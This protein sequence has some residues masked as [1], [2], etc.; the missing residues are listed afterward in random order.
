MNGS[1]FFVCNFL[2]VTDDYRV[3]FYVDASFECNTM[4]GEK[5]ERYRVEPHRVPLRVHVIFR[6]VAHDGVYC[7]PDGRLK[8]CHG[9]TDRRTPYNLAPSKPSVGQTYA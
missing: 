9:G 1:I 7:T 4:V 3:F 8:F 6:R 2:L 5:N